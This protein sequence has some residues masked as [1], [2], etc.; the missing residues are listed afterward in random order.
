MYTGAGGAV[1]STCNRLQSNCK[2]ALKRKKQIGP[3]IFVPSIQFSS[4]FAQHYGNSIATA[5]AKFVALGETFNDQVSLCGEQGLIRNQASGRVHIDQAADIRFNYSE[6][7]IVFAPYGVDWVSFTISSSEF[8]HLSRDSLNSYENASCDRDRLDVYE[9]QDLECESRILLSRVC[10]NE[11]SAFSGLSESQS[12]NHSDGFEI[13]VN[14]GMI[15]VTYVPINKPGYLHWNITFNSYPAYQR[16]S[17][18][19]PGQ[20]FLDVALVRVDG[21][22]SVVPPTAAE[23]AV[24]SVLCS[25]TNPNCDMFSS[26]TQVAFYGFSV[27]NVC[28]VQ[29]RQLFAC[30]I[31][32]TTTDLQIS[33][34]ASNFPSLVIKMICLPC[35]KGQ[36][37]KDVTSDNRWMCVSCLPDQYIIDP[38]NPRFECQTCPVGANCDGNTLVGIVKGSVWD[39]DMVTGQYRLLKC[40]EVNTEMFVFKN[41]HFFW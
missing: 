37:R 10:G 9:C 29:G 26:L 30:G 11:F 18:Y 12:K 31:N 5:P 32:E 2:I 34:V 21:L 25:T 7:T 6:C 24:S 22:Q 20:Q 16:R 35:S 17:G 4:N 28:H 33:L 14:T 40:P 23:S 19:V 8:N 36:A 38:N 41:I 39:A 13:F 1:Y 3:S 15:R 27:D